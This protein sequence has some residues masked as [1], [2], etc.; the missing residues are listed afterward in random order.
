MIY[1]Q[2]DPDPLKNAHDKA[3][4]TAPN[5]INLFPV[6]DAGLDFIQNMDKDI[7]Y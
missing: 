1:Q 5:P 3:N 7:Y 2:F 4:L 6:Y